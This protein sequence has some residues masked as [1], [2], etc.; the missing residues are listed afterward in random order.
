MFVFF[1]TSGW[2]FFFLLLCSSGEFTDFGNWDWKAHQAAEGSWGWGQK[3]VT[4]RSSWRLQPW[5]TFQTHEGTQSVTSGS[6]ALGALSLLPVWR[7]RPNRLDVRLLCPCCFI[8][9]HSIAQHT[10]LCFTAVYPGNL[11]FESLL[12]RK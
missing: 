10:F 12:P 11:R 3:K 5:L 7:E 6:G 8:S 1:F 9:I 4:W 2:W